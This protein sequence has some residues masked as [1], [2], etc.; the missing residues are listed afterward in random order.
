MEVIKTNILGSQNFMEVRKNI[1]VIALSTIKLQTQLV[2]TEQ[3]SL[4]R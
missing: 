3:Q 1:K 2:Y 4:F